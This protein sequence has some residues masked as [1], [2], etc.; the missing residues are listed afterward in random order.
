MARGDGKGRRAAFQR[1]HAL[2]EHGLGGFMI[3]V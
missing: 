3:R 2:F 1:R